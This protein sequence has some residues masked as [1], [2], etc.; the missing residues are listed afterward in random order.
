MPNSSGYQTFRLLPQTS[1]KKNAR[2]CAHGPDNVQS[3]HSAGIWGCL[4][5]PFRPLCTC[6]DGFRRHRGAQVLQVRRGSFAGAWVATDDGS[7]DRGPIPWRPFFA[8]SLQWPP[9]RILAGFQRARARWPPEAFPLAQ[10]RSG[11]DRRGTGAFGHETGPV[12]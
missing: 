6:C 1:E 5:G 10:L 2:N 3:M 7:G 8:A 11:L 9:P 12:P 4:P